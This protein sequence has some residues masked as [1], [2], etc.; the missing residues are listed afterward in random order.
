VRD[1][2]VLQVLLATLGCGLLMAVIALVETPS[3]F[4]QRAD[5]ATAGASPRVEP[6]RSKAALIDATPPQVADFKDECDLPFHSKADCP[7]EPAQPACDRVN[8]GDR[9][10]VKRNA[11]PQTGKIDHC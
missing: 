9:K 4:W 6:V 5:N 3:D 2:Y 11:Q 10:C 8:A 7:D 1:R